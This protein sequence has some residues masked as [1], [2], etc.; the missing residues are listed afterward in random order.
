MAA[1][2]LFIKDLSLYYQGVLVFEKITLTIP[3]N[4]WIAI[5]G[6]SGIGKSSLLRLIA[7]LAQKQSTSSGLI[8]T[9]NSQSPSQ[10]IAFMT[11]QD[12]LLPWLNVFDNAMLP[13]NLQNLDKTKKA[14][15]RAEVESLL[16]KMGLWAAR[17]QYPQQLSTGM[18][19]RLELI[20]TLIQ[21][22]SITLL[23]EPFAALD[24][25]TRYQLYPQ[26]V[27][28]LKDKT[29]LF[30]THDPFEALILAHEIYLLGGKP[31]RLEKVLELNSAIPRSVATVEI[32]KHHTYLLNKVLKPH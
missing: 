13:L 25:Q 29:V 27:D 30:T 19:K 4:R 15:K 14:E 12:A 18:Q 6:A 22:R 8:Y 31:A 16:T 24:T 7:G 2:T 11:Q 1:P 32:K 10:Q 21:D 17:Q 5:L 23:D 20:Q 3:A 28:S 26:I 9:D